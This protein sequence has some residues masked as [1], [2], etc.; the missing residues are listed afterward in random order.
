MES[1]DGSGARGRDRRRQRLRWLSALIA[2]L[3]LLF[4]PLASG[5]VAPAGTALNSVGLLQITRADG[6]QDRLQGKGSVPLFEGDELK[7]GPGSKALIQFADGTRVALNEETSFLIR[8]RAEKD[9]GVIRIL[10]LLLGEIWLKTTEGPRPIEIETPVANAA[11]RGTEFN[12]KV[13][14]DGRSVLTV[15]E[16]LVEFGTP[17]GTCPIRTGTQSFGERGKRCTKPAPTDV[18]PVTAW[19]AAVLQQ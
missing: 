16:G 7:T 18:V 13:F 9:R 19:T 11:I 3:A 17:F 8:S 6:R 1:S 10:K 14:P 4:P 15:V 2:A 12:M 5:Q